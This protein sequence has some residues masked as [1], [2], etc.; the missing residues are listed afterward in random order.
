MAEVISRVIHDG[1]KNAVVLVTGIIEDSIVA[2][3]P[4]FKLSDLQ[5]DPK[6]VK[7][8]AV[9]FSIQGKLTCLL[10]WSDKESSLIVPLEGR[11]KLDFEPY[12]GLQNPRK[13]EWN[14]GIDL[15][16][17]GQEGPKQHFTI[18]LDLT[19]Q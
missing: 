5:H 1:H 6:S 19:K 9:T 11:G 16:T 7:I 18:I 3:Q 15:S 10:W 13:E 2:R 12:E 14:G 17:M 8:D 4:I